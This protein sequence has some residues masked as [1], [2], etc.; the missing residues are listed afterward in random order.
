MVKLKMPV[1]TM[2]QIEVIS[3]RTLEGAG[4]LR[5]FVDI[6]IGGVLVITQCAVMDGKRGLFATLP[7]QLSR[8]GRWR[9][10]VIAAEDDI[11]HLYHEAIIKA[12]EAEVAKP[13]AD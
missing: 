7:R 11:R 2:D 5:A 8:D 3:V 10:V 12:Y 9:D 13:V 1:G 6:R 4:N